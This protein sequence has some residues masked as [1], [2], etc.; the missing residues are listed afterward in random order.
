MFEHAEPNVPRGLIALMAVACG[1]SVAGLYY[2]QPLAGPIGRSLGLGRG[3]V[4]LT[5]TLAQLGYVAGLILV[6]PLG[7]LMENRRLIVLTVLGGAAALALAALAPDAPVFLLA[8]LLV[9]LGSVAAQMLVP[10][11][12]H[13]AP[14]AERGRVVG[15]VMSGLLAGI[16]LSR[17]AASLIDVAFGWRA[18]FAAA[19]AAMLVLAGVLHRRLP[20][21]CPEADHGYRQLLSS[22]AGLLQNTPVLQRRAAYQ[23]CMFGAFSAFWTTAPL[24]LAG[25]AYRYGQSVIAAFALAGASGALI[26]PLAGR[27]ADRGL[28]R[29]VTGLAFAAVALCAILSALAGVA[30]RLWLLV[31]AALLL[32]LGVQTSQVVGQR[33]IYSHAREAL[34][35]LN[36]LYIALLFLGGAV[37]SAAGA[38]LYALGGWPAADALVATFCLLAFGLYATEFTSR[39]AMAQPAHKPTP[40]GR[41]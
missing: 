26:A 14:P 13:L 5:V 10:V 4:G 20:R 37:G 18:V 40:N 11:A 38:A 3:A 32:D 17:P 21:R 36:G 2:A 19:A 7:D 39:A 15:E 41:P 29:P 34:S 27:L 22:M 16:L 23:A 6:V 24:L 35:R 33:A 31:L 28:T 12:A 30:G 8:S 1:L 9:G 25:P